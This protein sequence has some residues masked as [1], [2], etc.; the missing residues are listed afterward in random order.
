M[1]AE[2]HAFRRP[3]INDAGYRDDVERYTLL[4][5]SYEF[6]CRPTQFEL[7]V[8]FLDFRC[9]LFDRR[10]EARHFIF[11]LRDSRLLLVISLVFF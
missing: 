11:E 4:I 2:V 5:V 9:L 8:H 3:G 10:G 6:L 7:H 1:P